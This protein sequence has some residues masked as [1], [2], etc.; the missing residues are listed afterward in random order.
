MAKN[1]VFNPFKQNVTELLIEAFEERPLMK[2]PPDNIEQGCGV[3]AIYYRGGLSHYGH[4]IK[5]EAPPIYVGKAVIPGGRKGSGDKNKAVTNFVIRR[6]KEHAS[7]ISK[8]ENLKLE[9]FECRWLL[10]VPEFTSAAEALLIN[11]YNPIWNVIVPG[12]GIHSPGKGRLKQAR[13]HWDMIHPGRPF[14]KGLPKGQSE[15]AVLKAIELYF[16]K[17]KSK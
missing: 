11:H 8:T 14:A 15:E 6:L 16:S 2:F 9:E 3:Y 4:L 7:S 12:F 10:V 17:I 13:S 5:K 1:T